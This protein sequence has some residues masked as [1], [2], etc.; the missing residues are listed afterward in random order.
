MSSHKIYQSIK[1]FYRPG[2]NYQEFVDKC[3]WLNDPMG[4]GLGGMFDN[5]SHPLDHCYLHRE[6]VMCFGSKYKDPIFQ[7][8]FKEYLDDLASLLKDLDGKILEVGAGD[9]ELSR[10]LKNR[11]LDIT[12]IDDFKWPDIYNR[13]SKVKK[14]D[15]KK[16]LTT[17]KP[18]IVIS[19]WMPYQA[20]WTPD[21]RAL[22]S[23]KAYILI[24]EVCGCCGCNKAFDDKEGWNKNIGFSFDQYNLCRTDSLWYDVDSGVMSSFMNRHH[25][26]TV[27]FR[28]QNV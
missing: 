13:W 12:A 26:E 2:M 10:Q 4:I 27:L 3:R 8:W 9:G 18:E 7:F 21:F 5:Y 1:E 16:A 14:M 11:G 23:V 17:F 22:E 19:S 15:Y 28:R 6:E 24:G 20:D 25:S